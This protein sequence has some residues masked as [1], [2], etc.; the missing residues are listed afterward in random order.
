MASQLP[1]ILGYIGCGILAVQTIP[2]LVR[3]WMQK[4][5]RD[6]SYTSIC[7]GL[8]GGGFT[9]AYGVMLNQPP[10]YTTVSFSMMV[11]IVLLVLKA[12]FDSAQHNSLSLDAI[13]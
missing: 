6:L 10:L 11:N 5:G 12:W 7:I 8:I 13:I 1:S 2:Q 4:S 9:V 3:V